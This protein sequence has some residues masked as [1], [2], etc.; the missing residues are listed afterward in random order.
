M[1]HTRFPFVKKRNVINSLFMHLRILP[2]S[3]SFLLKISLLAFFAFLL[4]FFVSLSK[5]SQ[6]EVS[7]PG[8][9][10]VEGVVG[11]PRFINPVLAVTRADKD[12]SILVY[13]GLMKL[14]SDGVLIPNIAESV[15]ISEDRLTYNVVLMDDVVFH[16]GV[17]LVAEDVVFTVQRIQDPALGSPLRSNFDGVVVEQ[18]GEH[19]VN[20]VLSEAYAPFIE[21]L[22]F[23]ILPRHVWKD[24]SDEEFPFSQHN[25]EPIG[26]GPYKINKI[27]RNTSGI[28][29]SYIL[30]PFA[31]YH[32]VVPK[33][34]RL[35][36]NFYAN[37]ERLV[38]AY[39]K[40][41]VNSFAGIDQNTL[42]D[43]EINEETHAIVRI[44][45][46]RTFAVFFNQ[47]KS[48]ALRDAG[49]RKALD[50]AID[51]DSL[52]NA[53][54]GGYGNPL[55][56]PIPP[57]F[58]IEI[59][60]TASTTSGTGFD[61]ARAILR[62]AG[63]K[64][65]DETGIWEKKI[66]DI[67]T[68]LSFSIA[69]VNSKVFEDTA[70]YLRTEWKKLGAEVAIKQFEQS[71]L[72]QAI[73]RP[74]DY[75]ALLFGTV[76]G[77]PLDFY[78][79]WHSSQRNDPG[80]NVA[81]YANITTDSVLSKA[82]TNSN[83]EEQRTALRTFVEEM[84]LETPAVFLFSPELLYVFPNQVTGA[85]FT[86]LADPSERFETISNW[87]INTESVWPLFKDETQ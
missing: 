77:R 45:L 36:L 73:I 34:S 52:V 31:D 18:I 24:A 67:T 38:D 46:P 6:V 11:T 10:L 3:D 75:E 68:P 17:P 63:W 1:E 61:E 7:T 28:P 80:L 27:N 69:T 4:L 65:N 62:G 35:T 2:A 54:L 39:K 87:F 12:M 22:T 26:A 85:T 42:R 51:R 8:G 72:T 79:F 50:A 84:R 40:G 20:F 5:E 82:R 29:E 56:S 9:N 59:E 19:E 55:Y 48:V 44:P 86:G 32:G 49:A 37:E 15:T 25:S 53:V 78:S 70:E 21:N 64:I 16:D 81:L 13:D 23:G 60:R 47:N 30:E 41:V 58:G 83:S 33:I 14:S 66:D 74:R 57:G 71:D 43:L 76:V